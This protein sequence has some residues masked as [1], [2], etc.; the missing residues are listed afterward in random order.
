MKKSFKKIAAS[1]VAATMLVT[2][3]TGVVSSAADVSEESTSVA[4]VDNVNSSLD[5]HFTN[6]GQSGA[7]ALGSCEQVR[8]K[9]C[10]AGRMT[11]YSG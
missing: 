5:Y 11:E 6:A 10:P 8:A 4:S 9:H 7:Y 2:G 1:L 3:M